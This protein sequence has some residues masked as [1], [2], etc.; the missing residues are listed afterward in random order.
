MK[1]T[2]KDRVLKH[3]KD[4]GNDGLDGGFFTYG[5][6][7]QGERPIPEYRTRI[8][9]LEREGHHIQRFAQ[10]GSPYLRYVLKEDGQD[11]LF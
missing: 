10:E 5:L 3:L 4:A 2:Q 1:M 9:E 6:Y 8:S 11:S 7:N